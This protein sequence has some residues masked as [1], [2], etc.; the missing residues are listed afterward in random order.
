MSRTVLSSSPILRATLVW[1]SVVGIAAIVIASLVGLAIAGS[2]GALGGGLG[3]LV[4]IVFPALSAVSILIANRW[5]G[6]PNFLGIFFGIVL[7]G[8]LLKF[9]IAIFAIVIINRIDAVHPL[10]FNVSL[11]ATAAAALVVDM[12]VVAKYRLPAVSDIK[13][14]GEEENV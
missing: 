4:G 8:W 13:M 7:G 6:D 5:Y 10:I 1:G 14:P 11:L 2:E 12:I 9:V 3:A